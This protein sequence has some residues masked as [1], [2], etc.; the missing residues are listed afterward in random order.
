MLS[1]LL[2]VSLL[3]ASVSADLS[4]FKLSGYK[5]KA[6]KE[7]S[8]L[9]ESPHVLSFKKQQSRS[10]SH[11]YLK[12][13][14]ARS[15]VNGVFGTTPV[16]PVEDG[17]VFI[18]EIAFGT[19][20]FKSVIDTGSSDTWLAE[21][22]FQCFNVSTG[23]DVPEADCY[24]G[25]TYKPSSTFTKIPDE[26]FNIS[27]ADGEMLIGIVGTEKV[28]LAGITVDNQEVG[29]VQLAGWFGDGVSS[30]LIGLAFPSITSAYKGNNPSV[31]SPASQ[32]P[33]NPVFFNM[34]K[35]G[36][37]APLFSLALDRGNATGQLALGGIPPVTFY[38]PIAAAPFQ[39]L[40][41][42]PESN[43][44]SKYQFYSIDAGF[45]Y[46]GSENA[47]FAK[48]ETLPLQRPASES[49]SLVIVDSGTTLLYAPTQVAYDINAQ[50]VPAAVNEEDTF[51]V[52]CNAKAPT[53]GVEVGGAVFYINAKDLIV[54]NGDGTCISGIQDAGDSFG[55]LGDVFLKNVLA[56]FDIGA[57]AMIF[58]A[59]EVY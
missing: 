31:D 54:P 8:P 27:Y 50:F 13:I 9:V 56:V 51:F 17:Q 25:S 33:Y 46:A 42:V 52:D 16:Q 40:N 2:V 35:E 7:A 18:T 32:L 12:A 48:S 37:V 47:R 44:A 29:V 34:F 43:S 19:E 6:F 41:A 23:A 45:V 10:V 55:I 20:N 36:H 1:S 5:P 4:G 59:R 26:N 39:V 22:G 49:E 30:G 21:K 15:E 57:S 3:A 28:T 58:A 11:A 24:F 53:F 38:E 14:V